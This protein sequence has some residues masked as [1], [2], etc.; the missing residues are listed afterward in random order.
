MKTWNIARAFSNYYTPFSSDLLRTLSNNDFY[1]PWKAGGLCWFI[2]WF[3]LNK[4]DNI[5]RLNHPRM[6]YNIIIRKKKV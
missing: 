6:W 3:H 2:T 5:M 4:S 1:I